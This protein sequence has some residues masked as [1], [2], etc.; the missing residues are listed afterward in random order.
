MSARQDPRV[1]SVGQVN[2]YLR[3]IVAEDAVL[4]G[5]TVRGEVSNCTYHRSGHLYF[6]LKDETG[7]LSAV[8]YASDRRRLSFPMKDGDMVVARGRIDVY[9]KGGSYQ[10]TASSI[11]LEGA[12]DLLLRYEQKKREL[13]EMGM[14]D[15]AYKKPVP[16]FAFRIGVV[17]APTGAA[18]R[19][20]I[21]ITRR[22]NPFVQLI[23]CPALV[24]GD[25]AAASIC[26]AI[27]RLD[28]LHPDV[29]IVG[30]GGGS[31]EDLWPFNEESV[32]RAIFACNT[33]VISAVGHE[34]DTTIADY[35]A[36]LRAPTPSAAAELAVF[37]RASVD[38]ALLLVEERMHRA[39]H[40]RLEETRRTLQDGRRRMHFAQE[41]RVQMAAQRAASAARRLW[42]VDPRLLL[43]QRARQTDDLADALTARM[44][45]QLSQTRDRLGHLAAR[46]E[47]GSPVRRLAAGYA[48]LTDASGHRVSGIED[49]RPADEIHGQMAG[50]RFT[51]A[52]TAVQKTA[53]ITGCGKENR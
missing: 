29:M 20:I 6:K 36:D 10:L 23:L 30:R 19:D 51:A 42:R 8:M 33:P 11:A 9:L 44:E 26:S 31:I 28:A 50:G 5:L 3:N 45:Q 16:R 14:F 21:Q 48:Y 12:G 40:L 35:V 52:V 1:F 47:A 17:T 2:S 22:R 25:Q 34:I 39:M 4:R 32:A 15:A 24:Q 43:Q 46:L 13:A 18:I 38:E 27:A 7:V 37:E 53:E 41:G 49:L